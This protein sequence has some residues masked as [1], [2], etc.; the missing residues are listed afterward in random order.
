MITTT[1]FFFFYCRLTHAF[2]IYPAHGHKFHSGLPSSAE[3][4]ASVVDRAPG[5]TPTAY[6]AR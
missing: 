4:E 3:P 1:Y 2:K 6:S 5:A